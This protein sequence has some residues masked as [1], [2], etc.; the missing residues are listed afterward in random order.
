MKPNMGD[1][2][3]IIIAFSGGKDSLACLLSIIESGADKSRIELW[4]HEIDG[5]ES[6]LMDWPVTPAYCKAIAAAFGIPLYFSWKEGGFEREMTR[7]NALTAQTS[8]ETPGGETGTTGGT[9]GKRNTRMM[10]PQVSADL[11]VR[12]CSAYLKID[13]CASAIRNQERFAGKRTLVVSGERGEESAARGRYKTFEP[14]RADNR[15]GRLARHVDR[16]RPVHAWKEQDVWDIIERWKVNPHPAY[17]LGWGRVSCLWCIFGSVNQ[18]ASAREI[19]PVGF[20]RISDYEARFGK[21][22]HRTMTIGERADAGT[23]YESMTADMAA[24][25]M[26]VEYSEPIFVNNWT[27]PPGAFGESCGPT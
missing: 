22:I 9:R 10:F 6:R 25:A 16:Y 8:F 21:T 20:G 18:C 23:P 5:R 3:H 4:H 26:S 17:H 24:I 11:N 7:E 14:D 15:D 13:V 12:W 2:D 27:L 1:Y 19:D